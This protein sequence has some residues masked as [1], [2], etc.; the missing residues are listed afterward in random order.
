MDMDTYD[1]FI[2]LIDEYLQNPKQIRRYYN[3]TM[4]RIVVCDENMRYRDIIWHLF[5]NS[6]W[7]RL[8][9]C[10][11]VTLDSESWDSFVNMIGFSIAVLMENIL[12]DTKP[13]SK[14]ECLVCRRKAYDNNLCAQ[15]G[16]LPTLNQLIRLHQV[17]QRQCGRF[18][19]LNYCL[20][21]VKRNIVIY[22]FVSR[23]NYNNW[24]AKLF[25]PNGPKAK[26]LQEHFE[27]LIGT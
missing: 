1:I 15:H 5:D 2:D 19:C 23:N 6:A 4:D 3:T 24:L 10:L 13:N 20:G 12:I 8:S 7:K 18:P 16:A 25:H 11:A 27:G 22:R 21:K 14:L 9:F 26:E 17:I